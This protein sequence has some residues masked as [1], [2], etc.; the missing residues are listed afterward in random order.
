MI[1]LPLL[2]ALAAVTLVPQGQHG[3]RI[4][5]SLASSAA[6][7]QELLATEPVE[8]GQT[9]RVRG[10]AV[11][12]G[13]VK[14]GAVKSGAVKSNA[15]PTG[16]VE[17]ITFKTEDGQDLIGSFFPSKRPGRAPAALLVHDAGS[18]R[19]LFNKMA[20]SLQKHGFAVLSVDLRG[21]G[22]SV[23]EEYD[24]IKASDDTHITTWAFAMR[25]LDAATRYLRSRGDVHTSNLS[26]V[27]VGAGAALAV[28]YALRDENA[29]AVV[30]VDPQPEAF[31]Y[32]MYRDV[33]DLGGLPTLIMA[34]KDDRRQAERLQAAA[35]RGND[36][37]EYVEFKVLK[38]KKDKG[39]L[40]DTRLPKEV[41][42]FL[43][44]E[45][46]PQRK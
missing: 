27:G 36:G 12:S 7:P 38:P 37:L 24:W 13:A 6:A 18:D 31:G 3:D 2:V 41:S 29:R 4:R 35:H 32:D 23:T 11:K 34:P 17:E 40:T 33:F 25:D 19:T 21:H 39:P 15:R 30:L 16:K 44:G 14:S 5:V 46:M 43:R 28:K 45:A 1:Q 26:L 20:Q 9:A 22:S 42:K 10:R 8:D